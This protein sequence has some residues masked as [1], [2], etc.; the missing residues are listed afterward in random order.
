MA[1]PMTAMPAA[2]APTPIPA[3]APVERLLLLV[4]LLVLL[5]VV[6]AAAAPLPLE[7]F[8]V[9]VDGGDLVACEFVDDL[10]V[11]A[12]SVGLNKEEDALTAGFAL[13]VFTDVSAEFCF[14]LV[15]HNSTP[16]IDGKYVTDRGSLGGKCG[17]CCSFKPSV[18]P[19]P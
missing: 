5:G 10:A 11:C 17:Q 3:C 14:E 15:L 9:D 6:S 19:G 8:A 4:L 2:A 1:N 18:L 7:D 12:L 16:L 13:A